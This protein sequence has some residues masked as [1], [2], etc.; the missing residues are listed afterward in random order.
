MY[1]VFL[2]I[3]YWYFEV[4]FREKFLKCREKL[5][6]FASNSCRILLSVIGLRAL[7]V[8]EIALNNTRL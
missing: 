3:G 6:V 4:L 7:H 8:S 1:D 2:F 5:Y